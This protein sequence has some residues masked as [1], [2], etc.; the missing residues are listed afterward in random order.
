MNILMIITFS[1]NIIVI[2]LIS[3]TTSWHVQSFEPIEDVEYVMDFVGVR[4]YE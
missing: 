3:S 4:Q 2:V 1:R